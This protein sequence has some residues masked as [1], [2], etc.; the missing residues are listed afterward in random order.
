[1]VAA[2][3]GPTACTDLP[4]SGLGGTWNNTPGIMCCAD[5]SCSTSCPGGTAIGD[6]P[7]VLGP[8]DGAVAD[9]AHTLCRVL[10]ACGDGDEALCGNID[11]MSDEQ[12]DE[13][14]RLGCC[15]VTDIPES[16]KRR[17]LE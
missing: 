1:V 15:S 16:R 9:Y 3:A 14:I 5:G 13:C 11:A 8:V 12:L 2:A 10:N 7:A 17:I 6:P 4:L